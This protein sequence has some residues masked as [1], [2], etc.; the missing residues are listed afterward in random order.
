MTSGNL[1]AR[2]EW[3]ALEGE[4]T[5]LQA[6]QDKLLKGMKKLEGKEEGGR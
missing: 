5:A 2:K 3:D 4:I 6:K 1:E